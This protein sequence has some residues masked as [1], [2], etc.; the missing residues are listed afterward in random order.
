MNV[1]L[2]A[3]VVPVA[4]GLGWCLRFLVDDLTR[5]RRQREWKDRWYG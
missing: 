2:V 5:R 3:I 4:I 1:V